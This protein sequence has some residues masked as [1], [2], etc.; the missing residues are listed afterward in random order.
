MIAVL[1]EC[2][3]DAFAERRAGELTLRVLPGG[4]PANTAAALAGLGTPAR[5]LGRISGDVFGELFRERLAGVD[6]TYAVEAREPSTLA[7]A[8]L[9]DAGKARYGFHAEGT[10]DWQ[11]T[12]AELAG[13][14][15]D[16]V[17]CLHTGSLAL[18]RPPGRD[19]VEAFAAAAARRVTVSVD[20]NV[21]PSLATREAYAV[22]RWCAFADILRL[23]DDDL[24]FLR[25][26]EPVE[27]VCDEWHAAGARLVVV[28]RGPAGALVS[29][30]GARA[31]VTAP[32]VD[33]VDTVGA[34][35][36]FTAGLLHWLDGRGLLGGRLDGLDPATAREAAAFAAKVAALAC[37]VRGADLPRDAGAVAGR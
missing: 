26:G 35:D 22:E 15:L 37:T 36:A 27:R 1:G 16:G 8:G 12:G 30:G 34:G 17:R 11:W 28:T 24:A 5:F 31:E 32:Q 4:G 2:V 10:A 23:S 18:V 21:R 19:V 6:L 14:V 3:A 29:L 25:P 7:V 33:V 13:P 20:P 9:D